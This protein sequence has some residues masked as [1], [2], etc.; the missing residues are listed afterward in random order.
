MSQFDMQLNNLIVFKHTKRTPF[1][2]QLYAGVIEST[3]QG[4]SKLAKLTQGFARLC[5]CDFCLTTFYCFIKRRIR[6]V[7][8]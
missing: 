2:M 5:S 6:L 4:V 1:T 3:T 7:D 8:D